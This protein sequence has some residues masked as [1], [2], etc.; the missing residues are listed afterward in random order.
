[1][2]LMNLFKKYDFVEGIL[3]TNKSEKEFESKLKPNHKKIYL[4]LR[5]TIDGGVVILIIITVLYFVLKNYL[6]ANL[7]IWIVIIVVV[8]SIIRQ[9]MRKYIKKKIQ[10]KE[11]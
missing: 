3:R 10:N 8:L 1:M 4:I 5:N 2:D 9:R 11:Y 6:Y 7:S